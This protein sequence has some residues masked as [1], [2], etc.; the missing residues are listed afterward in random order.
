MLIDGDEFPDRPIK[1]VLPIAPGSTSDTVM[2]VLG[3]RMSATLGPPIIVENRPG[4]TGII[5]IKFVK[6]AKADAVAAASIA[7]GELR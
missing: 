1:V 5:G 2:R 3:R 6:Q 7:V 4:A